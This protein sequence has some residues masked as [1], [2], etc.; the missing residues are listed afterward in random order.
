MHK[1]F[2][3]F[4]ELTLPCSRSGSGHFF[5]FTARCIRRTLCCCGC[6]RCRLI[7]IQFNAKNIRTDGRHRMRHVGYWARR[8]Q[9]AQQ[10]SFARIFWTK[11]KTWWG[12]HS[13]INSNYNL[14][15]FGCHG[16]PS[17]LLTVTLHLF[18]YK[19]N[20]FSHT[21]SFTSP[22]LNNDIKWE[23]LP[24]PIYALS[25]LILFTFTRI[26]AVHSKMD[27]TYI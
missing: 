10:M 27:Y 24:P 7:S 15:L 23:K 4:H 12:R 20:P 9:T 1:H 14:F 21:I 5:L 22:K 17:S 19:T 6:R 11:T 18:C 25:Y 16:K 3:I 8:L 2:R 26:S 13:E